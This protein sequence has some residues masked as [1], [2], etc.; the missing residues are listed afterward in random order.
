MVL[1]LDSWWN[2]STTAIPKFAKSVYITPATLLGLDLTEP[3]AENLVGFSTAQPEL[4]KRQQLLPVRDLKLLVRD[5]PVRC[6]WWNSGTKLM[7]VR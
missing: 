1:T 4:F 7:C 3:A 6:A 2:S 5:Y